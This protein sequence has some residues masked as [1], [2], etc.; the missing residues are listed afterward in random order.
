[1]SHKTIQKKISAQSQTINFILKE[2]PEAFAD[3]PDL[4][5]AGLDF[6]P[7]LR[8][9][10]FF[11]KAGTPEDRVEWLQWAFQKAYCQEDYQ[12][13]NESKFMTLI[14]SFRDTAG[15]QDLVTET[16]AQYREVYKEMGLEVK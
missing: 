10:G 1:M 5:D 6:D 7:L 16:I 11:V 3:V 12:A 14:E 9:R 2:A 4:T 15:S 8:F 13:Y